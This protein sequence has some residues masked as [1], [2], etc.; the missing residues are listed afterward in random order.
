MTR[1]TL[2]K[3]KLSAAI[4][5]TG[6]LPKELCKLKKL[7]MLD[8]SRNDALE[9]PPGCP[10]DSCGEMSYTS[11]DEVKKFLRCLGGKKSQACL[12]Q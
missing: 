10:L 2:T 12:L 4:A 5:C 11:K 6:P 1:H 7:G 3:M 8:L 9:K